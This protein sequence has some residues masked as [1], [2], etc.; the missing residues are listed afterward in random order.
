MPLTDDH[1]PMGSS[2]SG[3]LFPAPGDRA[4][5]CRPPLGSRGRRHSDRSGPGFASQDGFVDENFLL[6]TGEAA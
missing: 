2:I 1:P 4:P 5:P 3:M 6:D